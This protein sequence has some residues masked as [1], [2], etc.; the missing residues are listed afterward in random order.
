MQNAAALQ[1]HQSCP[2]D[3]ASRI[4]HRLTSRR[5]V[6]SKSTFLVVPLRTAQKSMI[7]WSG[8]KVTVPR[9][10]FFSKPSF[11]SSLMSL[12]KQRKTQIL[13]LVLD[14][15]MV[16]GHLIRGRNKLQQRV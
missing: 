1:Q 11:F 13:G 8:P 15:S 3:S 5:Q 7:L 10:D 2:R 4:Q 12:N 6:C 9:E 16:K 14:V